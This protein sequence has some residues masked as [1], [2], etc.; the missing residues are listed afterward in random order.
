MTEDFFKK[1]KR[2]TIKNWVLFGFALLLFYVLLSLFFHGTDFFFKSHARDSITHSV[3]W[4][5]G[6]F[7][8]RSVRLSIAGAKLHFSFFGEANLFNCARIFSSIF[9]SCS[10]LHLSVIIIFPCC[11]SSSY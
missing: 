2:N 9:L 11:F 10:S 5:V 6:C 3:G 7:V 4:S 1:K 8:H